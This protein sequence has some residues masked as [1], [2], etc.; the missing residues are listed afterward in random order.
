MRMSIREADSHHTISL[1]LA[2]FKVVASYVLSF[3]LIVRFAFGFWV[4]EA[5]NTLFIPC[6]LL[7][8]ASAGTFVVNFRRRSA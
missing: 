3:V 2:F 5:S 6:L 4:R 1:P 7:G 8:I